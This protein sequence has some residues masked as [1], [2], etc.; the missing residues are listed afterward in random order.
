MRRVHV[1][2][3]TATTTA[4]IATTV[5]TLLAVMVPSSMAAASDL[6]G[7][8]SSTSTSTKTVT[9]PL[10]KLLAEITTTPESRR[11]GYARELFE[12]W[13]DD[14]RD[15]CDTRR[16]VLVTEALAK[17]SSCRSNTGRWLSIYDGLTF[18]DASKLEVDHVVALAESWDSGAWNWDQTTRTRFANDLQNPFSLVAVSAASN[19]AKSDHDVARWLPPTTKGRCFLLT[20][21]IVTKWRWSLTADRAERDTLHQLLEFCGDKRVKVIRADI[22]RT[23]GARAADIEASPTPTGEPGV[24]S[25]SGQPAQRVPQTSTKEPQDGQC[26]MSHPVKG[27]V[28]S[29]RIY[30]QP[31]TTHYDRTSAEQCFLDAAAATEAGYR[32]PR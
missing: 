8:A 24:G 27:N 31:G 5:S 9:S 26:P 10:S 20:A 29:D 14:N 19:R 11:V 22:S 17:P 7:T 16:E 23:H 13:T 6:A 1:G 28:S 18:R 32:A 2:V 30:H 25:T 12:H 15:G 3:R 4:A 21:T